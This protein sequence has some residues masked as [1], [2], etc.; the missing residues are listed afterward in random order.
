MR[1][2][3]QQLDDLIFGE[4]LQYVDA[5]AGEQRPI[6]FER[7][8][9][10]GGAN[11]ANVTFFHVRQEGVLLGFV[12]AVNLVDEDDGAR[13]VLAGAFGIGHHLLDFFDSGEDRGE[14]DELRLGHARDNFCERRFPRAGRTPK[15]E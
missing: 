3:L 10:G 2:R 13:A 11:E 1:A 4:R 15:D 8:I 5:G 9:L 12:E 7:G 6:D 14:L